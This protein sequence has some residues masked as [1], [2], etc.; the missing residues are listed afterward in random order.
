M[1]KPKAATGSE[2][3][4]IHWNIE[5]QTDYPIQAKRPGLVLINKKKNKRTCHRVYFVLPRDNQK[6]NK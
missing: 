6:K 2:T 3:N 4:K 1:Y 5:I